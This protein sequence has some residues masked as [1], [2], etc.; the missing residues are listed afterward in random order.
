MIDPKGVFIGLCAYVALLFLI[1]LWVER[2]AAGGKSPVRN[3]FVYTLS[4]ATYCTAW[5][6]YGSVG[7]AANSGALFLALYLGPTLGCLFWWTVLRKLIRLKNTHRITSV[8]DLMAARY[9][10]SQLLAAIATL[11]CILGSLPYIA[12]QLKAVISTFLI[13]VG[14]PGPSSAPG[15]LEGLIFQYVG[16][17]TVL[18]MIVFTI[19]VGVRRLDPTERHEGMVAALAVECVVKLAA[20]LAVGFFVTFF[21]YSGYSDVFARMSEEQYAHIAKSWN[22]QPAS[23]ITWL[24]HMILSMSAILFLPRQFHVAVVEN[25]DERHV[26]TAMWLFP[27]YMFLITLFVMP[28]AFAGL[29]AGYPIQAADTYVLLLPLH[30]GKP[31]LSLLVFIGGASAAAGMIM[32]N[33]IAIATMATNHLL[34]PAIEWSSR[35]GGLKRYLLQC[36]WA[37]VAGFIMAGYLLEEQVLKP[38]NLANIGLISFAA[39]IQFAPP[40]LGG[41]FWRKG[42][43]QGALLGLGGGGLVWCYTQLLPSFV[44]NG[45]LSCSILDEGPL[46]LAALRPEDLFGLSG[47]DPISHTFIWSMLVNVSL[48]VMGSL[49]F[50]QTPDEQN[51]AEQFVGVLEPNVH[52]P[53]T[54]HREAYIDLSEKTGELRRLLSQYFVEQRVSEMLSRCLESTGLEEGSMVSI[55]QLVELHAEVECCLAGS[56]GS[57]AAHRAMRQGTVFT[58]RESE[59]LSEVY[60]EVLASLKVTPSEL[61]E[62]IDFYREKEKLLTQ[63]SVELEGK[64]SELR[65]EI[66]ERRRA[67]QA[68]ME[69]EEKFRVLVETMNAGLVVE[70]MNG[71]VTY[72]NDRFCSLLGCSREEIVMCPAPDIFKRENRSLMDTPDM[73]DLGEAVSYETG[74]I[75]K[76]G[77]QVSALVSTVPHFDSMRNYRGRF[78]VVT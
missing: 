70:D 25:S 26:L 37:V 60:S 21:I 28:I 46:G 45:W 64:V 74:W 5:T 11:L 24:S 8:A 52:R 47:L 55:G 44:R 62:R 36:R 71:T 77:R 6:Y 33:S 7:V 68:L 29:L 73:C 69:S 66:Q 12:L 18:V 53:H 35:I 42:S 30:Q 78:S 31:W 27:V 20:F 14:K 57:A 51:V 19:M 48:Y 54:L 38:Y 4:L 9:N 65:R 17:V 75:T 58:P 67:E 49:Y 13:V 2:R 16:P 32:V 15:A 41:I 22:T 59:D 10:K 34:L 40:I 50:K 23:H 3:G 43:T 1:A 76:D 72:V 56:I 39:A 63:H 61:K